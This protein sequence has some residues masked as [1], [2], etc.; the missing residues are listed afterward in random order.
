MN[1]L[2]RICFPTGDVAEAYY[3]IV[4]TGRTI[5]DEESSAMLDIIFDSIFCD[6]GS[7][8]NLNNV[9][10][11][12]QSFFS[13]GSRNFASKWQSIENGA[14]VGMESTIEYYQTAIVP[15]QTTEGE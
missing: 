14:Q 6:I 3:D 1:P 9:W 10:F 12:Y 2:R 5:R 15:V 7:I 13:S 11:M 8:Y 4:L